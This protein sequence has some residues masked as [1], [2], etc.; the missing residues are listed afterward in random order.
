VIIV[1]SS[2]GVVSVIYV[3]ILIIVQYYQG[4]YIPG[5]IKTHPTN[6]T[7]VFLVVP[8]I[9]FGYQ[10]HVSV[11]PIYSCFKKRTVKQFSASAGLA[12]SI[13]VFTYT[14]AATYGYWTFGSNI[15]SD[16][17]ESYDAR[18]PYVLLAII[19]ISIK[20]YTTY[21]ILS[22]CGNAA[23][24]DLW[25]DSRE[26]EGVLQLDP[27]VKEKFRVVSITLWFI[28][29]LILAVLMPNI[30]SVI[31]LL[32]SLAAVFIFIFPGNQNSSNSYNLTM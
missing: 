26:A 12:L 25:V 19:A 32:G 4:K 22:F 21:P 1:L 31:Q 7:D 3:T 13:C 24:S 30:G 14:V 28:G 20:T 5:E 6:W 17:L 18:D 9:C 10:C 11:I 23:V 27:R 8:T 15:E 2:V 29:S 16:I